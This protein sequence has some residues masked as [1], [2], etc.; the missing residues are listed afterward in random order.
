MS[1]E[2]D[3]LIN[4]I[5][6]Q[7]KKE[8][9]DWDDAKINSTSHAIAIAQSKKNKESFENRK[10]DEDGHIIV[11]ENV[12]LILGANITPIGNIIEE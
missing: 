12:Q 5:K 4:A 3:N 7:L 9:P 8:H 2:F 6:A 1:K 10:Y 11:A